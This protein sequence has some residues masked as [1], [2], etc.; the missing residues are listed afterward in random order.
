MVLKVFRYSCTPEPHTTTLQAAVQTRGWQRSAILKRSEVKSD[1]GFQIIFSNRL[2]LTFSERNYKLY[3]PP[4]GPPQSE[5]VAGI[6]PRPFPSFLYKQEVD[7]CRTG[8]L[9][10]DPVQAF[11]L[12]PLDAAF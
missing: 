4:S 5:I 8:H 1:P 10:N 2:P 3:C 12:F 11:R 9:I 7:G 6:G